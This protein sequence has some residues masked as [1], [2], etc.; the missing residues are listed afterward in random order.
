MEIRQSHALCIQLVY[1]GR[2]DD[3]VTVT[4]EIAITLVVGHDE[5]DVRASASGEA[6]P[7]TRGAEGATYR[8]GLH[9]SHRDTDRPQK[10][11]PSR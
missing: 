5:Y 10:R 8:K 7:R 4:A 9:R 6:V 3:G 1:V 11:D 2:L